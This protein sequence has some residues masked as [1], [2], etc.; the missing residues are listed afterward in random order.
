MFLEFYFLRQNTFFEIKKN[1]TKILGFNQRQC[2]QSK[3][4]KEKETLG[5]NFAF[6]KK[7]ILL[8]KKRIELRVFA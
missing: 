8:L 2:H 7:N 6:K 5:N 1:K 3:I 4:W